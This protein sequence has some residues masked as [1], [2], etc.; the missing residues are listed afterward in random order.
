MGQIS[1]VGA[2]RKILPEPNDLT[3]AKIRDHLDEQ[4][5]AFIA[6]SPFLLLSTCCEDGT[7]EVSP[8]GDRPGF[9]GV[10]DVRTVLL[11]DRA[12]NN[13][14][15]GLTNIIRNPNVGMIFLCP[16][17]GETL[18][19]AGRATMHDDSD[20]CERL[21]TRGQPAKLVIRISVDRA[22]FH[23]AR[24]LLRAQ[25]WKPDSWPEPVRVSFGK[26]IAE[27]KNGDKKTADDIDAFV[28]EGYRT[29][30]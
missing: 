8:K 18:R 26:I 10:E 27:V 11:P 7:L 30:L 13:I 14:A 12:G 4:S 6:R 21:A 22:Y 19:I 9:V 23:C 17:T 5:R 2:L 24:S 20:M 29:G 1:D 3:L 28:R 16:G 15:I 25:L